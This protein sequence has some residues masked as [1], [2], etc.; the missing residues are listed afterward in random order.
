MTFFNSPQAQKSF[1]PPSYTSRTLALLLSQ[2]TPAQVMEGIRQGWL[3][4]HDLSVVNESG[5]PAL[6]TWMESNASFSAQRS[7]IPWNDTRWPSGPE[8]DWSGIGLDAQVAHSI[9]TSPQVQAELVVGWLLANA[10]EGIGQI[11]W[12]QQQQGSDRPRT[13]QAFSLYGALIALGWN[14]ALGVA[15][16]RPDMPTPLELDALV[17]SHASYHSVISSTGKFVSRES[18]APL[19]VGAVQANDQRMVEELL[20]AGASP[21]ARFH[22]VP[23]FY[24]SKSHT[25]LE[26]LLAYGADATQVHP[27][28]IMPPQWWAHMKSTSELKSPPL[29]LTQALNAWLEQRLTPERMTQKTLSTMAALMATPVYDSD[30]AS[31][32][33]VSRGIADFKKQ[34]KKAAPPNEARWEEFGQTW[35]WPRAALALFLNNPHQTAPSSGAWEWGLTYPMSPERLLQA[36]PNEDLFWL[37]GQINVEVGNTWARQ[38]QQQSWTPPSESQTRMEALGAALAE[39]VQALWPSGQPLIQQRNGLLMRLALL[40]AEA[41][42]SPWQTLQYVGTPKVSEDHISHAGIFLS[43][44]LSKTRAALL[45]QDLASAGR[46]LTEALISAPHMGRNSGNLL[47]DFSADELK[48]ETE[49]NMVFLGNDAAA[50]VHAL[51]ALRKAGGRLEDGQGG[52]RLQHV[53]KLWKVLPNL[54]EHQEVFREAVLH[55]T[56]PEPTA[57]K[58]KPRF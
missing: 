19:L 57:S 27:S 33:K 26:L 45:N 47:V 51:H 28:G 46:W 18:D 58:T 7:P 34:A 41:G 40:Q 21:N 53:I 2:P 32:A 36:A 8:G 23:V 14:K 15:L 31:S 44:A 43:K 1:G 29:Q 11:R 9:N 20:R 37:I 24:F 56:L 3:D 48:Q 17:C 55:N 50:L 25:V 35:T 54:Q 49:E 6:V 30:T 16:Q 22:D 38:A 52:K 39:P 4:L 10:P 12:T 5:K 13:A 42:F